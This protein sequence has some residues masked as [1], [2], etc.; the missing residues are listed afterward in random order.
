[1]S[2]G[3]TTSETA[4]DYDAIVF[5]T[6]F[7]A[8]TGALDRVDIRG[9]AGLA[10]RDKWADGPHTYL[11]LCVAG[12]PNL[13]TITGPSSPSVLSN[14]MVSIE[15][16]VDWISDC[17]VW[18]RDNNHATIAPTEKAETEWAIH[19]EQSANLTLFPQANSWYIGANVPGKPRTFMA[20]VGGVDVYRHLCDAIAADN[21]QG[22]ETRPA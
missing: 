1:T 19:N 4:D 8:M 21:Y 22:F 13:F 18:M 20:Y 14:M 12:F 15:Q 10:L 2:S 6:G 11:G 16:H 9:E 5:A 7:D 3:V 17:I